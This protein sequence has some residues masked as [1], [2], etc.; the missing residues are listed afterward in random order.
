MSIDFA[1]LQLEADSTQIK[2]ASRDLKELEVQSGKAE[3]SV[4]NMSKAAA[5]LGTA[6]AA[7]FATYQI[8]KFTKEVTLA[9]ARYET[10]GVVLN[11][12]GRNAGYSIEQV[13]KFSQGVRESGIQMD[14][15][16]QVTI[17]MIQAQIDMTKASK[18]ARIAQDAA[19]IGNINSSEA[20]ERMIHGIQ[21]AEVEVLRGIGLTVSFEQAY[22]KLASQLGKTSKDLSEQEKMQARTNAVMEQGSRIAGVYEASMDTAGKQISSFIRYIN[23]FKIQMGL[24]FNPATAEVVKAMTSAMKEL[25]EAV[26]TPETQRQLGL[27]A[28]QVGE[29]ISKNAE[30]FSQNFDEYLKTTANAAGLTV[31]SL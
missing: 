15:A 8:T 13:N 20:L 27:I 5:R 18:L 19:V 30:L 10:L 16:R 12:V 25:T 31:K 29:W 2:S 17:R 7:A 28:D 11:Q 9:A 23:D 6:L 3:K 14:T 1:R 21:S 26:S 24:A 22:K 4:S